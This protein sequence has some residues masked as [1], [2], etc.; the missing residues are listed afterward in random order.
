MKK[1]TPEPRN[2]KSNER[3]PNLLVYSEHTLFLL[4]LALID[5][6]D[7]AC[8]LHHI[9]FDGPGLKHQTHTKLE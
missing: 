6:H 7:F 4:R 5:F 1:K 8:Q 9:D 2:T 3:K